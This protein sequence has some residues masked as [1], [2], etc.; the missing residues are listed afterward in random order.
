[1]K[2]PA[3]KPLS[4]RQLEE[5]ARLFGVL[6]ERSRLVLLQA[7]HNGP[8][9]VSRLVE[10]CGMKQANVSKHLG[11]LYDHGLVERKRDGSF[12]R[13][14][15]ADPVVFALCGLVCGKMER[16]SKCAAALFAPEI[17]PNRPPVLSAPKARLV[18]E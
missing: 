14:E 5:V 7:L 8:Q 18:R 3:H 17:S 13:Y 15:I 1:M 6:S 12:I 9:P 16:N 10:A 2:A 4:L 11:V